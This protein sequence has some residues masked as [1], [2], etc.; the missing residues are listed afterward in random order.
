[1]MREL[2][3]PGGPTLSTEYQDAL[4]LFNA[5]R[6]RLAADSFSALASRSNDSL[7]KANY[8]IEKAECHR[9]LMEYGEASNCAAAAK[10]LAK[11]DAVS[12]MQ[13]NYFEATLL[14]SQEKREEA[15]DMLS[16]LLKD[17]AKDLTEGEGRELYE[18]IQ[19]QRAFTL[20]HLERYADAN[21]LLD[22][23]AT[24][25]LPASSRSDVLCNLG[26]CC[27]E[28]GRYPDA[29]EQFKLA[30]VLGI[31]DEWAATCRY[32]WG[33]SLYELGDFTAARRQLILCL[34]SG[35][36]GPPPSYVYKLLAVVCRKL[37][38]G[39]EARAY[40]EL[41]KDA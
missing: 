29:G 20:M 35:A 19:L 32:Y 34:Q 7:E 18:Q 28:R 10:A 37:G 40:E 26:Q 14:V 16:R 2:S 27:F 8:L 5:G 36:D 15:L 13:I 6:F 30:E 12:V 9:Q 3:I 31:G 1:M 22:E 17:H 24:F 38:E 23:A 21:P 25:E 41:A 39:K 11:S 4:K 33:Y